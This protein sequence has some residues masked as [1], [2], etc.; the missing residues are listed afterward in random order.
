MTKKI[1]LKSYEK[2]VPHELAPLKY[3]S[4]DQYISQCCISFPNEPALNSFGEALSYTEFLNIGSAFAAYLQNQ[5]KLKKGDRI[6]IMLPNIL[7]YPVAMFGALKAGLVVVNINPLYIA[8]EVLEQLQDSGAVAIVVF[9]ASACALEKIITQTSVRHVIVAGVGDLMSFTKALAIDFIARFIKRKIPKW[10]IPHAIPFS[11][12]VHTSGDFQAVEIDQS[13]LAFLQYTG[14]TTGKQKG[15]MLS[16]GNLLANI[17]Q[18]YLWIRQHLLEKQ[19]VT[20]IAL[21]LYHIFALTVNFLSMLR[22]G[23]LNIL[24]ADPRNTSN[25]VAEIK[26]HRVSCIGGVNT[27]F[28]NLLNNPEFRNLDFSNLRLTVGGG[29]AI[30]S[31][32][33]EQWHQCTGIQITQ[34]YGLTE[35]S[36][37]VCCQ[38]LT[39]HKFDRSVG[40]PVPST[41]VEIRSDSGKPLPLGEAGELW[42]K[43][44]QVMSGYWQKPKETHETLTSDGW[45]RTGDIASMD[46]NGYIYILDREKDL[47]IVSGFNVYPSEVENILT[48]HPS[49]S[50][51]A[52]IG[53]KDA[54]TGESVK[55]FVITKT[56]SLTTTEIHDY[57]KKYLT[58]YKI[59]NQIAF[60]TE[61]PKSTVGKILRRKLKEMD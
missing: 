40:L 10:N 59:P 6:A 42:V 19:E 46:D 26:K 23:G 9:E 39:M 30:E 28:L 37:G 15:A 34:A 45:L 1:W 4:V 13:D 38:P 21:P 18:T 7:P 51:A 17:E 11:A 20:L 33:A 52:V 56:P 44:P 55:A 14:G 53:V 54:Q 35:A 24:I 27:L 16:H 8:R 12:T 29:S 2:G 32:V 49:I 3:S 36:P 22:T 43:G 48:S 41:L 57:C 50:E 60:V 47:I 61:L 58:H 31:S 25:L 5:L